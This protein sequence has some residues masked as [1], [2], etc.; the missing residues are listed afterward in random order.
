MGWPPGYS[1]TVS[2]SPGRSPEG[3]RQVTASVPRPPAFETA[4]ASS[5]RVALPM[6]ACITGC[7]TPSASHSGVVMVTGRLLGAPASERGEASVLD[8]LHEHPAGRPRVEERD[9]VAPRAPPRLLVDAVDA[10]V[11]G[12]LQRCGDIVGL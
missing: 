9:L 6:G 10:E 12:G 1:A 5:G 11:G 4:A 3:G 2:P 8:E 7:S